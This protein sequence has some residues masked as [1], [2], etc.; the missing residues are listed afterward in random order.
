MGSVLIRANVLSGEIL[1]YDLM[2]AWVRIMQQKYLLLP[3]LLIGCGLNEFSSDKEFRISL[4][5]TQDYFVEG[6]SA[7][8]DYNNLPFRD[9]EFEFI[10]STHL[11]EPHVNLNSLQECARLLASGGY[12]LVFGF[13]SFSLLPL[14]RV[15]FIK[16]K[17]S[18]PALRSSFAI[19]NIL[20]KSGLSIVEEQNIAYRPLVDQ[21]SFA[22][23][24]CM[25]A[26]GR[27]ILPWLGSCSL[28][29]AKKEYEALTFDLGG[30]MV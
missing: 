8:V 21:S 26:V 18:M 16:E 4:A 20:I 30:S 22:D 12:L 11:A 27:S 5:N 9:E 19:K 14:Q 13:S 1:F 28:I 23:L 6:A 29:I 15:F 25:E 2:L 10:I 17:Q 24:L 3:D 7:W